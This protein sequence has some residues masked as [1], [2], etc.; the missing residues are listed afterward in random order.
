MVCS[1]QFRTFV[2]K[3]QLSDRQVGRIESAASGLT[4]ALA[5]HF[6]IP[7]RNIFLQGSF[8]NGS[9]VKPAPSRGGEYD[10]DL[11]VNGPFQDLTP[12]DAL[13]KMRRALRSCGYGEHIKRDHSGER[14]CVRLEYAADSETVAFHVDVVPARPYWL[15]TVAPLEVPKPAAGDWKATAPAEYTRWARRQGAAYIRVVQILKRWRDEN[16]SARSAVKSITLQV[17]IANHINAETTGT[18]SSDAARV[19]AALRGVSNDLAFYPLSAPTVGNPVL[20]DE[21]LAASWPDAD[22][23]RFR[24]VVENA[25]EAAEKA[26]AENTTSASTKLWSRLLGSDFPVVEEQQASLPVPAVGPRTSQEAPRS[27]W[28]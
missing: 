24:R 14:P 16:Q 21:N 4:S 11:V 17:M 15:L 5:K 6:E 13:S 27:Q 8:A 10:V 7:E 18:Y 19:V 23:Q 3:L 25:A 28:A 22:Y 1:A 12:A 26:E 2:S 20:E 9:A